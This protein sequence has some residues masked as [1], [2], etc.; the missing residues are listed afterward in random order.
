MLEFTL[1]A[2]PLLFVIISTFWMGMGMWQYHTLTEAVNYTARE[3]SVHGAGC[4]GQ[5]CAT[6]IGAT[7]QTLAAR[8]IGIPASQ[9]NVTFS[10]A[11]S[12]ITCNPL[13]AC[14]SGSS[15]WPSL[16]GNTASPTTLITITATYQFSSAISL[17]YAGNSVHFNPITLAANISEPIVF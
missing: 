13:T 10:S 4:A 11:A 16:A 3:S 17:W 14:T 1:V 15:V 9:L 6:T 2:V 12:S 5:T 7:A 8:A